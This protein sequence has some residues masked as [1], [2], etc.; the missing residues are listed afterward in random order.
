M[1]SSASWRFP[2][3]KQ[4]APKSPACS[5]SKKASTLSGSS[6]TS[7][8][9]M[10]PAGTKRSGCPAIVLHEQWTTRIRYKAGHGFPRRLLTGTSSSSE[11][12]ELD[13]PAPVGAVLTGLVGRSARRRGP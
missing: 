4:S 7:A 9:W 11:A 6:A 3:T 12:G 8:P 2:V 13:R 5:E 10:P 1:I